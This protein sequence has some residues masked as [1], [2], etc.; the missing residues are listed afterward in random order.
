MSKRDYYEV[1][2]VDK[3]ASADEIKKAYRKLA[4]K[5]H[6]D[7]NPD[8]KNAEELFKEAAEAYDVLST[9]DKKSRY[10]QF[11][12][13]G[14]SNNGGFGGGGNFSMDDIFS[15]FGDIF[16]G[17]FGGGFSG[18]GFGGFGGS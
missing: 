3:N 16:G 12:H 1:L 4:L 5:Y 13:A 11:G 17:H 7:R 10:D 9:P 8:D 18:G 2:G 6:P 14:M 15:N